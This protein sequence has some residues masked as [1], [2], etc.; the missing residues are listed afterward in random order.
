MVV[1]V[2]AAQPPNVETSINISLPER[3]KPAT[4]V[5]DKGLPAVSLQLPCGERY[6]WADTLLAST[7]LPCNMARDSASFFYSEHSVRKSR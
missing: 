7:A 1:L 5:P 3:A 6:W 4:M 2:S